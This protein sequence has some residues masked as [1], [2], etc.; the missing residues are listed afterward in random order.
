MVSLRYEVRMTTTDWV[1][2]AAAIATVA[3]AVAA[4]VSAKASRDTARILKAE[5]D[6]ER[7]RQAI[8]PLLT[9][10]RLL[11]EFIARITE[12][13]EAGPEANEL[14]RRIEVAFYYG[15]FGDTSK[16]MPA[17]LAFVE[18]EVPMVRQAEAALDEVSAVIRQSG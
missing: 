1:G 13:A 14:H 11:E 3:A 18:V 2:V 9:L 5:H 6:L 7:A 4:A 12:S 10:Q 16:R 8:E 17:T 15:D